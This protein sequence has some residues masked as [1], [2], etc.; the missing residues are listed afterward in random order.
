MT[1]QTGAWVDEVG[2]LMCAYDYEDG[3]ECI[4]GDLAEKG[5]AEMAR[6]FTDPEKFIRGFLAAAEHVNYAVYILTG[7][8]MDRAVQAHR[9]LER[10]AAPR[11]ER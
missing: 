7:D 11:A 4:G 10:R 2:G 9:A 3:R 5:P 1:E 6:Q 8:A